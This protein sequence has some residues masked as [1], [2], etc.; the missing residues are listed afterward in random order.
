MS[1]SIN[2]VNIPTCFFDYG[3][4]KNNEIYLSNTSTDTGVNM[5][6]VFYSVGNICS[7]DGE[8]LIFKTN[9][10]YKVTINLSF[11]GSGQGGNAHSGRFKLDGDRTIYNI[12][13]FGLCKNAAVQGYYFPTPNKD[14]TYAD[15]CDIFFPYYGGPGTPYFSCHIEVTCYIS[16]GNNIKFWVSMGDTNKYYPSGRFTVQKI[17]E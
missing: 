7:I 6:P 10:M 12:N 15:S 8:K 3:Y 5:T 17:G 13:C 14:N 11:T 1:Y 4:F 2:S 9:G 16:A